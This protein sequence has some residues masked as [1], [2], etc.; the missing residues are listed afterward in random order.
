MSDFLEEYSY[1]LPK[2]LI[3]LFPPEERDGGKLM[4]LAEQARSDGKLEQIVSIKDLC[5]FLSEGDLL[6]FNDTKVLPARLKAIRATGGRVEIF[7]VSFSKEEAICL[8][9]PS[10]RL[11]EGESLKLEAS[12]DS[13]ELLESLGGGQW[14]IRA[15]RLIRTVLMESGEMPIPPYLN[16]EAQASEHKRYQTIFAEKEGAV[17]APT[18]GLHFTPKIINEL[19]SKGIETTKLTLHVGIGTFQKLRP[20]QLEQGELHEEKYVLTSD[21][22]SAIRSCRA[23]GGRIVAVGTT[24]TRALEAAARSEQGLTPHSGTTKIFI[25]PGFQFQV[26]DGLFTNFHLPKSSLLMLVSAF[27]GRDRILAAYQQAVKEELRFFSYGDAM[28]VLPSKGSD[29][30]S[31]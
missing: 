27:A 19:S 12:G 2:E 28:L 13:L 7:V 1:D 14:R 5:S 8:A 6:I 9:R 21:T 11:R 29:H 17:A 20:E 30:V 22:V 18:A 25:R 3:A 4:V 31:Y 26:I 23:R 24:V 16:R 10:R 15:T